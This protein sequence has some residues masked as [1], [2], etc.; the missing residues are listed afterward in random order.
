MFRDFGTIKNK[1]THLVFSEVESEWLFN[2]FPDFIKIKILYICLKIK[3][4]DSKNSS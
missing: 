4:D 3:P 1:K 2:S